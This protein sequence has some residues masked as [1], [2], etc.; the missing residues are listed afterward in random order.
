MMVMLDFPQRGSAML[1]SKL[2]DDISTRLAEMTAASPAGDIR[3]NVRALLNSTFS[4]LD[5]V[6]R[7]GFETQTALLLHA[8]ARLAA[9]EARVTALEAAAARSP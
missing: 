4:S 7:E 1:N 2:F 8:R 6:T 5:L 9:L 3:K